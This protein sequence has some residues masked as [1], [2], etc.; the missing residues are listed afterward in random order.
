MYSIQPTTENLIEDFDSS[1]VYHLV[2]P[3]AGFPPITFQPSQTAS[4]EG[5]GD[6]GMINSPGSDWI[7]RDDQAAQV[8]QGH[9]I[10]VWVDFPTAADGPATFA[11]GANSKADGSPDKTYALALDPTTQQLTLEWQDLSTGTPTMFGQTGASAVPLN[12]DHWY[13]LEVDWQPGQ[14]IGGKLLD[15][16]GTTVLNSVSGTGPL[17]ITSG[18]F[19]FNHATG[20]Q[21]VYWDTV[22]DPPVNSLSDVGS[23]ATIGG[24]NHNPGGGRPNLTGADV[25]LVNSLANVPS[26]LFQALDGYFANHDLKPATQATADLVA[27]AL[28]M[29]SSHHDGFGHD[30]ESGGMGSPDDADNPDDPLALPVDRRL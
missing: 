10:F 25:Q 11:F 17:S 26:A 14:V 16:D 24:S 18:G 13:R 22:T 9:S 5:L 21:P 6:F 19:G 8:S 1:H 29:S 2:F 20:S 7:Y 30:A 23:L 15:S 27:A 28:Q 3:V 4:H 12:A